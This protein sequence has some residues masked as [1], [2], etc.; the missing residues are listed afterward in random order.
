MH[1][2]SAVCDGKVREGARQAFL[3]ALEMFRIRRDK[4][5]EVSERRQPQDLAIAA[6]DARLPDRPSLDGYKVEA[7]PLD[8]EV[9]FFKNRA[10]GKLDTRGRTSEGESNG[11]S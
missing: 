4:P 6:V 8:H 3:A 5:R 7:L 10:W 1:V 9:S 2:V 11:G